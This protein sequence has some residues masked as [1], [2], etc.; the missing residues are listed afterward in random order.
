MRTAQA[1]CSSGTWDRGRWGGQRGVR[2]HAVSA[3]WIRV[4]QVV[5]IAQFVHTWDRTLWLM[6]TRL[7]E[8]PLSVMEEAGVPCAPMRDGGA[9]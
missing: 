3:C 1:C 8:M 4:V 5:H 7:Q 2:R 6:E 9:A